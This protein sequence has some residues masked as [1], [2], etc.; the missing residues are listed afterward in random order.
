MFSSLAVACSVVKA[1]RALLNLRIDFGG[2]SSI[3]VFTFRGLAY[4]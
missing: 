3:I 2:E 1:A 4:D